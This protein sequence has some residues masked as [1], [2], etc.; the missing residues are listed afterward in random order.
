MPVVSYDSIVDCS[1]TYAITREDAEQQLLADLSRIKDLASTALRPLVIE[2][3]QA[4]PRMTEREK[5]EILRCL[6]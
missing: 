1:R 4:N 5:Q 6:T 2:A 3:V